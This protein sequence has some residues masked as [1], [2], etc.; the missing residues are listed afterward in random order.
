[1]SHGLMEHFEN[2]VDNIVGEVFE[3]ELLVCR[4]VA[5]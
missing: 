1:M 3:C 5:T 4:G 2:D